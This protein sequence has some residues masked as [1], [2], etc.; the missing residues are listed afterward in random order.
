MLIFKQDNVPSLEVQ[1]VSSVYVIY[2]HKKSES[3][4]KFLVKESTFLQNNPSKFS[5]TIAVRT[6]YEL[7]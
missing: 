4:I 2:I 5:G 7:S 3:E 1:E 6:S